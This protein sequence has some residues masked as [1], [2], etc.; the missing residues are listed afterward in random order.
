M[1]CPRPVLGGVAAALVGCAPSVN[2]VAEGGSSGATAVGT[3]TGLTTSSSDDSDSAAAL[4]TSTGGA[5]VTS[6]SGSEDTGFNS[7]AFLVPSDAGPVSEC[8]QWL[9]DCP[10]GEKCNAWA[11]DGGNAWN[12]TKCVPMVG[13]PDALDEPCTVTD[14]GVSGFDTCDVGLMCWD[15]DGASGVG[16]CIAYCTGRS[17]DPVCPPAHSCSISANGVLSICLPVCDPLLQNC[18]DGWGCYD[19]DGAGLFDCAPDASG[20]AGDF[21][22]PCEN[23]N[24]CSPGLRCTSADAQVG[25]ESESCCTSFC[26][27]SETSP[28]PD[29]YACSAYFGAGDAPPGQEDHGYCLAE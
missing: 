14:S 17:V 21:G 23:I 3:S 13:D 26:D 20:D 11:N 18:G 28:C 2:E 5:A 10:R 4:D 7:S 24:E 6:S 15:V 12:A 8:D 25:C 27:T 19:I 29:G 22:E 16:T 1:R 9:Q